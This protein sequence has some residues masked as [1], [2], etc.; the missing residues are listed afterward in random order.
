VSSIDIAFAQSVSHPLITQW[1]ESGDR[2]GEFYNPQNIAIDS[3]GNVYITD[4]GNRRVQQFDNDGTFLK[5]WGSSG[6]GAGQFNSV[7]GIAVDE[8]SVY[9][10]DNQL[11]KIQ[12]F[13]FDGNFVTQWG[14]QGNDP[15][16]FM[17]PSGITIGS[18]S[19]VLVVDTGN[20][21]IQQFSSDGDFIMMFGSSGSSND[22]FISPIGITTDSEDNIY[23]S[24]PSSNQIKIF[25]STGNF[26]QAFGPNSAGIS[27]RPHGI[28]I[29]PEGNLYVADG[30]NDRI[31]RLDPNGMTLTAFGSMGTEAGQFKIAKDVAIDKTGNLFVVDSNG[32]RIQKF[33]TPIVIEV[34]E[35]TEE[36]T[37]TTETTNEVNPVPNDF[38]KP[39][40]LTPNDLQIEATGGLTPVSVGQAMATDESGIQSLTSNAPTEFPIGITTVI[41]TAID[42]AGNMAIATQTVTVSDT[43]PP[44][45]LSLSDITVEANNPTQNMVE[46]TSPIA[47]DNVGVIS[48]TNDAPMAFPIGETIVTWTATDVMGN[49]STALQKVIVLD[50]SNPTL[51]V[52]ADLIVEATSLDQNVISLGEATVIDNGNILSISNDSPQFFGMG[53]TT[54][55]WIASDESGNIVTATQL[56]TVVDT[57]APT[58]IS[59]E[60][61]V[62]EAISTNSNHVSIGTLNVTDIQQVI[63]TNNALAAFPIG[64][65]RVTWT[66]TDA[67]GNFAV[68]QQIVSVVDTTPPSITFTENI[69]SE[70][71]GLVG[72]IVNLEEIFVE[73]ISEIPYNINDAPETFSFGNTTVTWIVT[74]LYGNV[75]IKE[76]IISVIDTTPPKITAPADVLIEAVDIAE[77]FA[78][79]GQPQVEDI[80][81]ITLVTNDA[82]SSFPIGM[83]TVTWTATDISGNSGSGTQTISVVDSTDPEIIAPLDVTSETEGPSGSNVSI[84]NAT[85]S[86]TIGISTVSNNAP[87]IFPM[88]ETIVTWTVTDLHGN[89]NSANQTVS[90]VDTIPPTITAPSNVIY[91]AV[92]PSTNNVTIGVAEATDAVGIVSVEN[93]APLS[94]PVGDTI[95]TWTATDATGISASANQTVSIVDTI[96]PTIIPNE[97]II[98]EATSENENTVELQDPIV[99]DAVGVSSL[100]NDAPSLFPVGDTIVTWN[101]TDAIGNS[102]FISQTVSV[103]D[104]TAPKLNAPPAQT[105][106]AISAL[107]NAVEYGTAVYSDAVGV[108]SITNDAPETFAVGLTS[109]TWTATD[110]AGNSASDIQQ[111]FMVDTTAPTITPPSDIV[112]EAQSMYNN[113]VTLSEAQAT[114]AVAIDTITND[115]PSLFSLG[116]T[117]VTWTSTDTSGNSANATQVIS[118]IDTTSPSI[119]SVADI[120]L[121]ATSANE[122]QISL[123]PPSA[124]DSISQVS[125]TNDA[126]SLF[127]LGETIVIWTAT[128][129]AGNSASTNQKISIIDTTAPELTIPDNAIVDATG[130]ETIVSIGEATST[131]LADPLPSISND[132][133]QTFSLGQTLVTWTAIDSFG[134]TASA[135]QSIEVQACGK[136]ISY[137]N[138]IEGTPN[139]DIIVGTN[140]PDLIFAHGG[141]DIISGDKGNDCIFGG[142]GDDIIFGNEGNDGL[143]GDEGNDIIKG[144]SGSDVITSGIGMDVIDGGDDNDSC[145]DANNSDGDLVV[146]CES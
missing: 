54:V 16:Q 112:V 42:G 5:A 48:I 118:V 120:T 131:D 72:N 97:I 136:P 110:A 34:Q 40:I 61:I 73:D 127:S 66:A 98:V 36:S 129:A 108:T 21:R 77:N 35:T 27:L 65:T 45:I 123:I 93:N 1:G 49:T 13:D 25:N 75:A 46:L 117:I 126:P 96:A 64:D 74:D 94:F 32:H 3:E 60:N 116:E 78:D 20:H 53:N 58:I 44:A 23:V 24:D 95:V 9:V 86:D 133:S 102:A 119:L 6:S 124:E 87:T 37:P 50:T 30:D 99:E 84:G 138:M 28:T 76:Q 31:L 69:V 122:N 12:K 85:V 113:T 80:F 81:E 4:L 38:T 29:D 140:L 26:I 103:V 57:I 2:D 143:N 145:I 43:T 125:V 91:E 111:I 79:L 47:T 68:I 59:P 134:N 11:N 63:T 90:V 19:T 22:K 114:D 88:G 33:D 14:T 10:V 106:E 101:A 56:V 104:T 128:D 51:Y 132:A 17:Y 141:D 7:S 71:T 82:P 92:D 39:T 67:S 139:D 52:P 105:V 137:Y 135:T 41:W 70:A 18:N 100:N 107:G 109:I 83:T 15:G 62:F 142:E 8:N 130:L 55:T 115:A 144:Q 121:E 146:K 89:E